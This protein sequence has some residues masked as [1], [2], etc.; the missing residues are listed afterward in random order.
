MR[1]EL[2]LRFIQG[3]MAMSAVWWLNHR[4][5]VDSEVVV[6]EVVSLLSRL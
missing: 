3:A 6:A 1:G 2:R 5:S 4:G